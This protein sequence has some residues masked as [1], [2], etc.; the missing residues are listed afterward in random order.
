MPEAAVAHDEARVR[1][2]TASAGLSVCELAFGDWCGRPSL[3]G[4]QDVVIAVKV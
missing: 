1:A 3:L 4:L 2:Y